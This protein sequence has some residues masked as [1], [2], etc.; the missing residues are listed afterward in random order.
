MKD[1]TKDKIYFIISI[2]ILGCIL[3]TCIYSGFTRELKRLSKSIESCQQSTEQL[4]V[5][6]RQQE[7]TIGKLD[8][9][10]S[11][12]ESTASEFEGSL[13]SAEEYLE[14][15]IRILI[16]LKESESRVDGYTGAIRG[17]IEELERTIEYTILGLQ[18]EIKEY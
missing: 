7:S 6:I 13:R 4:G 8:D 18:E 12:L 15:A 14:G 3:S 17:T 2:V 1:E 5:S 9:I 10:Q 11:R 16:E